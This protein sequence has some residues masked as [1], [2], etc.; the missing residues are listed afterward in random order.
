MAFSPACDKIANIYLNEHTGAS[1]KKALKLLRQ[2]CFMG[3][4]RVCLKVAKVY[5]KGQLGSVKNTTQAK[6]FYQRSCSK[7]LLEGCDILGVNPVTYS[8]KTY[9]DT[10]KQHRFEK[11]CKNN[12]Y[13]ACYRLG[14]MYENGQGAT[15]NKVLAKKYYKKSCNG[16]YYDSC[17]N[18]AYMHSRDKDYDKVIPLYTK[19][20]DNGVF[21]GCRGLGD[22]YHDNKYKKKNLSLSL[23]FYE[24]ACIQGDS[25]ACISNVDRVTKEIQKGMLNK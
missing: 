6:I 10:K 15:K 20:C 7:F 4:N 19:A 22:Y 5:D 2:S 8:F 17:L 13:W 12:D 14:D 9:L 18:L 21:Y 3:D 24:K 1:D 11:Q 25:V 23:H 16:D